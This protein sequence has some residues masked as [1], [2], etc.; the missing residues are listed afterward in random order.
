M[1]A[2]GLFLIHE[3]TW[4]GR[5]E[6]LAAVRRAVFICEQGVPE[7]LEWDGADDEATHVLAT[8]AAG[9]PIGTARLLPDGRIGRMAVLREWRGCGVGAALL[10]RLHRAAAAAGLPATHLHAQSHATGF[11]AR[12]GYVPDGEPFMEA[13]IPHLAMR[14]EAPGTPPA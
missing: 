4:A 9:E 13:G 3:V 11:Y 7:H 6:A 10:E 8:T 14:R 2:A 1:P 5:T 12:Y